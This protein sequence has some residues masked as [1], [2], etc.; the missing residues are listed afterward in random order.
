MLVNV[1]GDGDVSAA[2]V[3]FDADSGFIPTCSRV[4]VGGAPNVQAFSAWGD[5]DVV[6]WV[7]GDER[8]TLGID[9]AV[10]DDVVEVDAPDA[11]AE[12]VPE[13]YAVA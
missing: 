12:D 4:L 6:V 9:F 1:L 11:V 10:I 3:S 13:S 2:R 7:G 5:L 8:C